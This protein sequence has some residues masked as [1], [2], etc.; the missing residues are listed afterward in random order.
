MGGGK[1]RMLMVPKPTQ[2]LEH[3]E[4]IQLGRSEW[5][6]VHTPGHT[7]DHLCLYDPVNGTFLSGDHVLPTITP[8]IGGTQYDADRST[9]S[10]TRCV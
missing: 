3:S 2:V 4:V 7:N 8:H 1:P 5:L 9:A 10:S 6:T